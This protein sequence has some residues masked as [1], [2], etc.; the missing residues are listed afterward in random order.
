MKRSPALH[1]FLVSAP[2]A[3][4]LALVAF[5]LIGEL[6]GLAMSGVLVGCAAFAAGF[7]W[8]SDRLA[9]SS[10]ARLRTLLAVAA[11][12]VVAPFAAASAL[13]LL[14]LLAVYYRLG[15]VGLS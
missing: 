10:P 13:V 9:P 15:C 3:A 4:L 1:G 8:L 7:R 14:R 6:E 12:S 11:L 5:A 2:T